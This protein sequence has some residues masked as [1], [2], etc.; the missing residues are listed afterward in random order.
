LTSWL[1]RR[2]AKPEYFCRPRQLLYR[3]I[4]SRSAR[5]PETVVVS[6]PW[7]FPLEVAPA[8]TIGG[9]I[10]RLG[11]HELVVS[12][13]LWRLI[14][15][16]ESVADVGANSGYFTGLMAARAGASGMVSA[17][18]PHP[19]M[20]RRLEGNVGLWRARCDAARISV[21]PVALSDADGVV[22]LW[23]PP[24]FEV[25]TGTAS[26]G[27][28]LARARAAG[29]PSASRRGGWTRCSPRTLRRRS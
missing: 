4:R 24:G 14:D 2:F 26:I 25:N 5:A 19:V 13:V 6:M 8:E 15:R 28:R 12:E 21:H 11:V 27:E 10:W 9:G 16:G 7:G 18:E 29:N 1:V 3:A 23:L 20:R 17:F 22:E